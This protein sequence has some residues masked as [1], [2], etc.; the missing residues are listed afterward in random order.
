L[1]FDYPFEDFKHLY[2]A[3]YNTGFIK[4]FTTYRSGTMTTVLSARDEKLAEPADE[5]IILENVKLSD[6][7]PATM[8][9]L[10][11]EGRKWYL[12][13]VWNEQQTRPFALFVHTN[14][15]EKNIVTSNAIEK[16]VDLARRKGIPEIHIDET[17]DKISGGDNVSKIARMISLNLRHGVLIKNIVATLDS[18]EDVYVGSF[19]FQ[20]KKFLASF[21]K[22]GET[23][24]GESCL[25]CGSANVVYEEGC[26]K[27]VNCGSSKC[28]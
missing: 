1:P 14:N 25:Q 6:S 22:D 28:G 24:H 11:A 16:L 17:S 5:E 4:G 8:K 10:K 7:A 15:H 20:I 13:V 2:L 3:V 27:C 9:T 12:S 23:V 26:K 19:L 21:I 18:I